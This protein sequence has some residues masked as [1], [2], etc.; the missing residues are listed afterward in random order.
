MAES[1][2]GTAQRTLLMPDV[3]CGKFVDGEDED[4]E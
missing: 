4:E 1:G 2:R 3:I